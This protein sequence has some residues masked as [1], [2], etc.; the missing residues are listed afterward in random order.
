MKFVLCEHG[1]ASHDPWTRRNLNVRRRCPALRARRVRMRPRP[2]HVRRSRTNETGDAVPGSQDSITHN[3][4]L[5]GTQITQPVPAIVTWP[6][7]GSVNDAT[8]RAAVAKSVP[9]VRPVICPMGFANGLPDNTIRITMTIPTQIRNQPL[10]SHKFLTFQICTGQSFAAPATAGRVA[11]TIH[12]LQPF[13][14]PK[15][16]SFQ[17]RGHSP[18]IDHLCSQVC[19]VELSRL[20]SNLNCLIRICSP[21]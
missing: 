20:G 9:R 21:P 11:A 18:Q 4:Q 13:G 5:V 1:P 2:G 10:V 3:L 8:T 14:G 12:E 6:S 16:C 15:W 17:M 7:L 19:I